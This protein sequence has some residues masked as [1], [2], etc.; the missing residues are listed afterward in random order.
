M[1][2][3]VEFPQSHTLGAHVEAI[4]PSEW[5][6]S[7]QTMRKVHKQ[8]ITA[9]GHGPT[10]STTID[11]NAPLMTMPISP[12]MEQHVEVSQLEAQAW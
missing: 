5:W 12:I 7:I 1:G 10:N 6:N 9:L 3:K 8:N 4:D 2:R 11:A